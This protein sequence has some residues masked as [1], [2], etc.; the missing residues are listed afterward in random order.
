MRAKVIRFP[1]E[2]ALT[3]QLEQ[4]TSDKVLFLWMDE[5]DHTAIAHTFNGHVFCYDT[6]RGWFPVR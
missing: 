6:K 1:T 2:R 5:D 3:A 4:L